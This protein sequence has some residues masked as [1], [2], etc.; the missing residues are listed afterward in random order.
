MTPKLDF[1]NQGFGEE[2][3]LVNIPHNGVTAFVGVFGGIMSLS[4]LGPAGPVIVGAWALNNI[5]YNERSKGAKGIAV[6]AMPVA[7]LPEA[8]PP[9]APPDHIADDSN[10]VSPAP[11]QPRSRVREWLE[12]VHLL[13]EQPTPAPTWSENPNLPEPKPATEDPQRRAQVEALVRGLERSVAKPGLSRDEIISRLS[14]EAPALLRL[15]KAPPIRLV[16]HQRTGK[17]TFA[18]NLILL[19]MVS[20][21]GHKATW[22]TPNRE[23]DNPVPALFNPVGTTQS[24]A[25]D[26]AGI[27]ALWEFVQGQINQGQSIDSSVVW[28]EFGGYDQFPNPDLLASSLR[29]QLREATKHNYYPVLIAHGDQ[30][31]FYPGIKGLFLTLRESTVKVETLGREVDDFGTMAPTGRVRITWLDGAVDEVQWPEWLTTET[32]LAALP[33]GTAVPNAPAIHPDLYARAVDWVTGLEAESIVDAV[34][35]ATSAWVAWGHR[36]GHLPNRKADTIMPL[37]KQLEADGHI[38]PIGDKGRTWLK[39]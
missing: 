37:L 23:E 35:A 25:K 24:G 21:P 6:E 7:T 36:N 32:L 38:R 27:Q 39:A 10:M 34:L 16:G 22:A 28:D 5:L 4:F 14:A 3:I 26:Y 13:A 8:I 1:L 19:R 30:A 20:F 9:D 11:A 2:P 15:V 29:S 33:E 12:A 18:R 17:S 31:A